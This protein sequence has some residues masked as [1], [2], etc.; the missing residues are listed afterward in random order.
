MNQAELVMTELSFIAEE[1][2]K[3]DR[4]RFLCTLFAPPEHREALFAIYAFNL[5][6]AKTRDV[7][8]EPM[9]GLM[10]L[11]W[12][13]E[14]VDELFSGGPVRRHAVLEALAPLAEEGQLSRDELIRMI[15]ARE[16]DLSGEPPLDMAALEFYAESSAGALLLEALHLLGSTHPKAPAIARHLGIAWA[17]TGI[18]RSAR[19]HFMQGKVFFPQELM[20]CH[21]LT[22][23]HFGSERFLEDSARAVQTIAAEARGHL[24]QARTIRKELPLAERRTALHVLL[25]GTLTE[26]YLRRIEKAQYNVFTSDLESGRMGLQLR[27]LKA[28]FL[29]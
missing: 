2:R 24:Q 22:L 13:R 8:S 20:K 23:D 11:A 18:L 28:A 17:L 6:I 7:V 9:L 14:A 26:T 16:V 15:D 5:E 21:N 12:W 3:G 1:V 25:F 29:P 19:I 27:L 10:R 4:D